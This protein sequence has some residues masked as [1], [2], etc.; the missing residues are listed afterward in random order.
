MLFDLSCYL[1]KVVSVLLISAHTT[2]HA[3][4][5][6]E[7]SRTKLIPEHLQGTPYTFF[8]NIDVV[9]SEENTDASGVPHVAKHHRT[10]TELSETSEVLG[11]HYLQRSEL[12]G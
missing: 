9:C 12:Q 1:T 8:F 11:F 6:S 5:S 4:N 7:V 3:G 2:L 10:L